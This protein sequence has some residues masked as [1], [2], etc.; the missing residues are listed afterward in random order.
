ML[1]H[2][3]YYDQRAGFGLLSLLPVQAY[4][5]IAQFFW[6]LCRNVQTELIN[7]VIADRSRVMWFCYSSY[8]SIPCECVFIFNVALGYS[9]IFCTKDQKFSGSDFLKSNRN[10][11]LSCIFLDRKVSSYSWKTSRAVAILVAA[12]PIKAGILLENVLC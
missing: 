6:L 3:Q 11:K 7:G 1:H 10:M 2:L 4:S 9:S 8:C 12:K 5:W